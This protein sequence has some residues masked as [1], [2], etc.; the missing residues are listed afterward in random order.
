MLFLQTAM[1]VLK[2]CDKREKLPKTQGTTEV[3]T[4][5]SE[6]CKVVTAVLLKIQ[7]SWDVMLCRWVN[8]SP[9]LLGLSSN[10]S[11]KHAL[12]LELLDPE[13]EGTTICQNVWNYSPNK[14]ASHPRGPESSNVNDLTYPKI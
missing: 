8:I 3:Q 5:T 1:Q 2:T 11:V 10:S 7:V 9:G 6:K 4:K 12:L 14:T 13:D